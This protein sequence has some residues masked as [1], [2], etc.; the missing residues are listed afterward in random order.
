MRIAFCCLMLAGVGVLACGEARPISEADK[1]AI[2]AVSDTF[3]ARLKAGDDSG[4]AELYTD[5]AV[6]MAPN[7]GI[8]EGRAAIRARIGQEPPG[9]EIEL[10]P[11]DL[12]GRGDLAYVRGTYVITLVDSAGAPR[13][14]DRGKYV[15]VRRRGGGTEWLIAIDIF[16][17]DQ[18]AAPA[19]PPAAPQRRTPR[20]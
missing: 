9:L 8:V 12:D 15:E 18:P 1:A 5:N 6:F 13:V 17:S 16:N 10:T 11:V 19:S 2:R 7:E 20:S 4:V 14:V 3:E